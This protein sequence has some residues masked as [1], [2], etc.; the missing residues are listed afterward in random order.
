MKILV[1]P[2]SFSKDK[3]SKAKVLLEKFADEIVYNPYGRPLTPAEIIPLLKG[4][5]GYIAGLDYITAEVIAHAPASLKVISRYGTGYDRVDIGSAT[6]K[7]ITVTNTPGVN[8]ES[9]ADLTFGLMLSVS[10]SIPFL[11]R[12]VR[13]GNWTRMTGTELFRKKL[14]ILGL[15]AVGKRVA[16]R[17]KG[18]SMEVLAH[19]PYIDRSFIQTNDIK[20]CA[21]DE[22]IMNAD[23]ISIHLP[24]NE[25]TRDIIN[26]SVIAKMKPGVIVV[27]TAR[28]GLIDEKAAFKALKAGKIGGLGLDAFDKEPPGESPLFQLNNVVATPHAGSRTHEAV[29]NMGIL[30]VQNLINVLSGSACRFILNK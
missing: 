11:D 9:V 3:P 12:E 7:K 19:D 1:T 18:F 6:Q 16:L 22:L 26:A 27:N 21:F 8:S 15:G 30:A 29:Y 24:L 28:G 10:R 25:Q 14:G 23:F 5:D 20:E 17:A 2:T 13:K 4:V